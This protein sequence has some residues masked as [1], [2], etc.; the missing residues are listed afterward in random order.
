[1]D[2]KDVA[3][4]TAHKIEGMDSDKW[5]LDACGAMICYDCY[6]KPN[7]MFCWEIDHIFPKS[8]LEKAGVPQELIDHPNNIRALNRKNNESKS[9]NYPN[10]TRSYIRRGMDNV[11]IKPEDDLQFRGVGPFKQEEIIELYKDYIKEFKS[12]SLN[13]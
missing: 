10:Y 11:E 3:W 6:D 7:L 4:N 5:R 12:G 9:D 1:M 2:L 8:S 13:I